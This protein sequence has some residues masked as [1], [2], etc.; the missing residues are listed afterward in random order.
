MTEY[1]EVRT[2][3]REAGHEQRVVTFKATQLIWLLYGLLEAGLALRI[4][5]KMI[6]VNPA[7]PFAALVYGVTD[8]LVAPF[9]NL[10]GNPAVGGGVLE[11]SSIIAMIIYALI[12]WAL[13]R[14]VYV[15][16][17]RPSGPVNVRQTIVADHTDH[18]DH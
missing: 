9:K 4:F 14:L 1:K 11:V 17:Y 6:A 5:F 7:N 12:G 3:H 13:E 18:D 16:F 15:L 10:I 2:E 8:L